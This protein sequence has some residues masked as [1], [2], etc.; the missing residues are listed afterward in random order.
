MSDWNLAGTYFETC[1]CEAACPCIFLSPPSM[2]DCTVLVGWHIDQGDFKGVSLDNLNVA[3]AV[4]SPG[5][6]VNG[7]WKAALYV[8]EKAA[9]EQNAALM[10]IFTGKAGG[11]PAALVS[12]VTEFLGA[13][14]VP[15][16]YESDGK[17]R[18][19]R[20]PGVAEAE[21]ESMPGAGGAD[22][23][24]SGHP[25]CIAPGFP[26]T[27]AKSKRLSYRDYDFRWEISDRNGLYSA[28]A[29][30]AG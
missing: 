11:H 25:L 23:A 12:F 21:I 1:N 5:N 17:I 8:D 7:N 9:P 20:I 4:R 24:I 26:A 14:T 13:R 15:I 10:E 22:V 29:Y 28:F 19:L 30:Q 3:L 2:G 27:V 16:E 6:M 18:R